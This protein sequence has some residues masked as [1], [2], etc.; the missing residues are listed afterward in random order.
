M[1][2]LLLRLKIS[3][4]TPSCSIVHTGIVLPFPVDLRMEPNKAVGKKH[5]SSCKLDI[6]LMNLCFLLFLISSIQ[7][8]QNLLDMYIHH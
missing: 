2:S 5:L 3:L 7:S 1:S 6:L 4:L 8:F